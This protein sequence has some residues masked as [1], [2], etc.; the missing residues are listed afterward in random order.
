MG[1]L[2][3]AANLATALI[4][5]G[6]RETVDSN[7]QKHDPA[8]RTVG[9]K[10]ISFRPAKRAVPKPDLSEEKPGVGDG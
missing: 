5:F 7:A 1:P 2:W 8:F 10:A 4:L 9:L 3:V 6:F